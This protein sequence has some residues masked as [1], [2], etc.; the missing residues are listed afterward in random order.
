MVK[1]PRFASKW[2]NIGSLVLV[3]VAIIVAGFYFLQYQK[4]QKLLQ[5]PEAQAQADTEKLLA[6]VGKI[7]ALPGGTPTVAT[8]S[9]RSKLS[10]QQFFASAENGDKVLIYTEAK[11]AILYRPA[12]GKVIE[13]GPITIQDR[14]ASGSAGVAGAADAPVQVAVYNGTTRTGLTKLAGDKLAQIEGLQVRERTNAAKNDYEK[15]IVVDITGENEAVVKAL[16]QELNAT[17]AEL[18]T[19]EKEPESQVLVILGQ[20]YQE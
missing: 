18:P 14:P 7:F 3:S 13:V 2:V 20:D 17:V 16:A 9:D 12:T 10:D 6:E 11:K 8:V 19:G 4:S 5:N 15:T 1:I